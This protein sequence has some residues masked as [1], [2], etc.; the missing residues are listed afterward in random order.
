MPITFQGKDARVILGGIPQ[1]TLPHA[2]ILIAQIP[3][4]KRS[5]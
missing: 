1:I 2:D 4:A 5:A 3:S